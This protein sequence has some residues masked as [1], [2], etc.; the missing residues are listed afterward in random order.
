MRPFGIDRFRS[1]VGTSLAL[2]VAMAAVGCNTGGTAT[3]D[4][5]ASAQVA[6]QRVADRLPASNVALQPSGANLMLSSDAIVATLPATAG[7]AIRVEVGGIARE[8]RI[9]G[10][11]AAIAQGLQ[12]DANTVIY[13]GT[14]RGASTA[15]TVAVGDDQTVIET[16]TIIHDEAAPEVYRMA[17]SLAAGETLQAVDDSHV[18][19]VDEEGNVQAAVG[20]PWAEDAAGRAVPYALS[21]EGDQ[22]A[23]TVRHQGGGFTYPIVADPWVRIN[24]GI[25]TCSIYFGRALTRRIGQYGG[26]ASAACAF[27]PTPVGKAVCVAAI[28]IIGGKAREC[29]AKHQCLRIRYLKYGPHIPA[30]LYC[31]GSRY[32]PN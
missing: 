3:V 9:L 19:V 26:A 10:A 23:M 4:E 14:D 27:V 2:V 1:K 25:V 8:V 18:D 28:N 20:A 15:A 32:C 12:F 24:C 22:I 30:G 6:M 29:G 17:V 21:V 16:H 11:N 7:E 13:A 31:D 5:A